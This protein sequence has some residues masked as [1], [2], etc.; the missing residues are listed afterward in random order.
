[1]PALAPSRPRQA[2][3]ALAVVLAAAGLADPS[4]AAG[5]DIHANAEAA[6]VG[7]PA[8][9]GAIKK[10]DKGGDPSG[11]SFGIWGD[12]FG[13]KLA[14]V[15]Y[16]SVDSV[17]K[18]AAFYR[19]ALGKYGPVLDCSRNQKRPD[20]APR[21]KAQKKADH[22][23]PVTCDDDDTIGPAAGSTR[24]AATASSG[25]SRRRRG[26]T[27]PASSCCASSSTASTSVC[28]IATCRRRCATSAASAG[29]A[30]SSGTA[31][32]APARPA[33]A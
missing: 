18:V 33:A 28:R 25:C 12:S 19:D 4:R 17:D 1:M 23:K 15:S 3:A 13:I 5:L 22:D 14:V 16:R 9:P 31:A 10:T 6:D 21:S 27:A 29:P 8:Y 20:D 2:L 7:L 26:T 11:F 24:S 30:D 32:T